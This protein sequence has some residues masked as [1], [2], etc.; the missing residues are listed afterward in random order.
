M[1][2]RGQ[3]CSMSGHDF[4]NKKL[5]NAVAAKRQG[6]A[7]SHRKP[8]ACAA[9]V[10]RAKPALGLGWPK[11]HLTPDPAPTFATRQK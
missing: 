1:T 4:L 10:R 8:V 9:P 7:V 5:K 3:Y 11:G 6:G 2:G